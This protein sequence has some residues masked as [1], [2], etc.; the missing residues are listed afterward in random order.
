[1]IHGLI[2]QVF[3]IRVTWSD[4]N[5]QIIYRRYS[6][7][8]DLQVCNST[9]SLELYILVQYCFCFQ[10][11][12]LDEFPD[13]AG[14]IYPMDRIIPFL[15]GKLFNHE[16][17]LISVNKHLY[18]LLHVCIEWQKMSNL[19]WCTVTLYKQDSCFS[20]CRSTSETLVTW[21]LT[22]FT[23][24]ILFGRSHIREV[25]LK[26]LDPINDY[27]RELV[28]LP[29]HISQCMDV[30]AFFDTRQEDINPQ[31]E[32]QSKLVFTP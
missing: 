31:R 3:V 24:K 6:Q 10:C 18:T 9:S 5:E 12:L 28:R 7:F 22:Y 23:G 8:F 26:R 27:C 16:N 25:A 11:R 21:P 32:P 19:Q 2:F 17:I 4:G 30:L 14:E 1:M 20:G 15:P 29:T 13:D